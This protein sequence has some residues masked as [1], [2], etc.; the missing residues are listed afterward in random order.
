MASFEPSSTS[1]SNGSAAPHVNHDVPRQRFVY[2]PKRLRFFKEDEVKEQPIDPIAPTK[3]AMETEAGNVPQEEKSSE[4]AEHGDNYPI[5]LV[6]PFSEQTSDVGNITMIPI[7]K[8]VRQGDTISPK[9]FTA[10]LQDAMKDLNWDDKGYIVDESGVCLTGCKQPEIERSGRVVVPVEKTSSRQKDHQSI[11]EDN[12]SSE[13]YSLTTPAEVDPSTTPVEPEE[14]G[15][16]HEVDS[17]HKISLRKSVDSDPGDFVKIDRADN[18]NSEEKP[19]ADTI[20][21]KETP[22][23]APP[24]EQQPTKEEEKKDVEEKKSEEAERVR[25]DKT[26][27][28]K[29]QCCNSLVLWMNENPDMVRCAATAAAVLGVAGLAGLVYARKVRYSGL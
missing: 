10:A 18:G 13:G 1:P 14:N 24:A 9:L 15:N 26:A 19:A 16:Q 12:S 25:D 11:K 3:N 6:E 21:S 5:T 23:A 27:G 8:G 22:T 7:G 17:G 29:S 28:K 4:G 20:V 2:K